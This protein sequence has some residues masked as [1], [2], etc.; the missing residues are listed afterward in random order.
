M[1]ETEGK[2]PDETPEGEAG[3]T[4]AGEGPAEG[5]EPT[6][7]SGPPEKPASET[8]E[9]SQTE[10]Q[11][12]SEAAKEAPAAPTPQPMRST[13]TMTQPEPNSK[14]GLWV[15]IAVVV[16]LIVAAA[17]WFFLTRDEET[18]PVAA[19]SPVE[20]T[21]AWGR[22]DGVGGG[23][24]I[25]GSA[26]AYEVT[27]YDGALRAGETVPATQSSDGRELQFTLPSQFA[28]GGAPTGP[29]DAILTAGDSP[30]TATLRI[31]DANQT[32]V[33]MPLSRVAELAP[34]GGQEAPSPGASEP[35]AE[36]PA[37]VES[38]TAP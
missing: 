26:G 15:V 2:A 16:I 13:I 19:P 8:E 6:Q 34:T 14:W 25:A 1:D 37:A 21:G 24:L 5:G 38:P 20:W 32:S 22:M 31:T 10:S 4:A 29:F 11:Q 9:S 33:L 3:E 7:D 28:F 17:A 27:L 23:L 36:S 30:D 35:A 18:T 12:P